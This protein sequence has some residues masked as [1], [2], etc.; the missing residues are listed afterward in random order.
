MTGAGI[1]LWMVTGDLIDPKYF[2]SSVISNW[3][4][5]FD[6]LCK[7]HSLLVDFGEWKYICLPLF[8]LLYIGMVLTFP[9][10]LH[11]LNIIFIQRIKFWFCTP[12]LCFLFTVTC[13][14][15]HYS[16]SLRK[17]FCLSWTCFKHHLHRVFTSSRVIRIPM[18]TICLR[19]ILLRL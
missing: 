15:D 5:W 1:W 4:Y 2:V 10:E 13:L 16:W 6:L 17:R 7:G 18:N 12:S 8:V 11:A 9:L 3:M 19:K 14:S